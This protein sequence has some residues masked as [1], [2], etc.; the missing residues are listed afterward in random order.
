MLVKIF[1]SKYLRKSMQTEVF[2]RNIKK[3]IKLLS[4]LIRSQKKSSK[5]C[6]N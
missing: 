4:A 3:G 6:V 1:Y 5:K 2:G